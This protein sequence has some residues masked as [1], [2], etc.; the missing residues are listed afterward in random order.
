MRLLDAR[1][2]Q[3]LRIIQ[4]DSGRKMAEG[5]SALGI[6]IGE[7]IIVKNSAPFHGPILIEIPSTQGIVAVGRGMASKVIVEEVQ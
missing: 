2:G 3:K 7:I 1:V 4:Y 5:L 6:H